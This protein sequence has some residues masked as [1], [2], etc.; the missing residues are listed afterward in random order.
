MEGTDHNAASTNGLI[1]QLKDEV[2]AIVPTNNSDGIRWRWAT[3]YN[4]FVKSVHTFLQDG[5]LRDSAFDKIWSTRAPLKV[6]VFLWLV[7]RGRV[8]TRDNLR[9]RG[10]N[11][12][13]TCILCSAAVSPLDDSGISVPPWAEPPG[14]LPW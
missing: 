4:F 6:R 10:W 2:N 5:G 1:Q 11:G 12:D 13:E 3:S 7:L 14:A 9:K 8:R